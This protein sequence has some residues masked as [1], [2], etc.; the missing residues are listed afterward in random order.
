MHYNSLTLLT[1]GLTLTQGSAPHQTSFHMERVNSKQDQQPSVL[2][3][4]FYKATTS[5]PTGAPHTLRHTSTAQLQEHK[6]THLQYT[7][8]QQCHN[9]DAQYMYVRMKLHVYIHMYTV[10][11]H[12]RQR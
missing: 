8:T 6:H 11:M 5:F 12:A 1:L 4:L 3:I 9:K 10:Y 7:C 2:A